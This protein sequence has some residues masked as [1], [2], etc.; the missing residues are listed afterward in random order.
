MDTS[1][2]SDYVESDAESSMRATHDFVEHFPAYTTNTPSPLSNGS[3]PPPPAPSQALVRPILT[4][5]FALS[6]TPQLLTALGKLAEEKDLP[7]QTHISEN[8]A[9]ID[10]VR[11]AFPTLPS[12]AAVYDHFGLL[13][14]RTILAHG[15]H[16]APSEISLIASRGAGVS[17][18]PTS[19]VNLNSGAAR[20]LALLDAG[21]SVGLGSDCSGGPAT[22][23]L[24]SLR[25]ADTVSRCL[26]FAG[27]AKRGLSIAE[28]WHLATRGGAQIAGVNAGSFE[29]GREFDALWI[30]PRSPGMW[31]REG[32][33]AGAVFEKWL[34][35]GDD[36]DIGAVWV[37]GR[38]VSGA[39]PASGAS[40]VS[41]RT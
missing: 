2:P 39:P 26:A 6:C 28:M 38:C 31:V 20:V 23:I 5:R 24:S 35:T 21:V 22:G 27:Q 36:R 40:G 3:S 34:F 1:C 10:A 25:A 19:N 17:H 12:Y 4:P 32:E 13:T 37:R 8:T 7:I 9:E 30:R 29:V 41:A 18:C 14:P 33:S 15:V 16:L 11:Q